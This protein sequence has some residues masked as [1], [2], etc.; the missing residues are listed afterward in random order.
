MKDLAHHMK[1][2][3]RTVIR[4]EHRLEESDEQYR[5]YVEAPEAPRPQT[6]RQIK[7]QAKEAIAHKK[8]KQ[9]PICKPKEER[10]WEEQHRTPVFEWNNHSGPKKGARPSR[11][12]TPRI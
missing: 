2:L 8:E 4:D 9:L 5:A 12:K 3:N 1:K 7:K 11:K 10:N 6:D